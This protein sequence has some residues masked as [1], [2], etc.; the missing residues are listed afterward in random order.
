MYVYVKMYVY[1]YV[2]WMYVCK[3]INQ[4]SRCA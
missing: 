1:M 4:I 2:V 3:P